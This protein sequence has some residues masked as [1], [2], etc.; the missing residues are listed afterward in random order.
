MIYMILYCF[1]LLS[2]HITAAIV[3]VHV[4]M[5]N[6]NHGA[7]VFWGSLLWTPITILWPGL[8]ARRAAISWP[9]LLLGLVSVAW[10]ARA[11][12]WLWPE[13]FS[14]TWKHILT[15]EYFDFI[16]RSGGAHAVCGLLS[17]VGLYIKKQNEVF[18]IRRSARD[19]EELNAFYVLKQSYSSDERLTPYRFTTLLRRGSGFVGEIGI[20]R[21]LVVHYLRADDFLILHDL[22]C[23]AAEWLRP[24]INTIMR[25][26]EMQLPASVPIVFLLNDITAE[27]NL[28]DI[29]MAHGFQPIDDHASASPEQAEL[30]ME[31][32]QTLS[33]VLK[34]TFPEWEAFADTREIL[35]RGSGN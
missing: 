33:S 17:L 18:Q 11:I 8:N 2:L 32:R 13:L 20:R 19:D 9:V 10:L 12:L 4:P 27:F 1:L 30:S 6:E 5:W 7:L 24:A 16:L 14:V 15:R 23:S 31:I 26:P 34:E 21:L 35:F 3:A 22:H 29:L 25:R 28:R